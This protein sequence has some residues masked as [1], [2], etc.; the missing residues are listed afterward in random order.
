VSGPNAA[1]LGAAPGV[2]R[3]LVGVEVRPDELDQRVSMIRHD[4]VSY[5]LWREVTH[6]GIDLED[7]HV[8]LADR[9]EGVINF[10]PA[11]R[12]TS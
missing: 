7:P 3:L 9:A 12:G 10:A 8:F 1:L 4:G 6:F 2:G 5:R 11:A